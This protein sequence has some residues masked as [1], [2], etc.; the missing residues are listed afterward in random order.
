MSGPR[1]G[2]RETSA[3]VRATRA[4]R[5]RKQASKSPAAASDVLIA[6]STSFPTREPAA[7]CTRP[8]DPTMLRRAGRVHASSDDEGGESPGVGVDRVALG[9]A[10]EPGGR[11]RGP[12][13]AG[14]QQG[15][16]HRRARVGVPTERGDA[17]EPRLEPEALAHDLARDPGGQPREA[18]VRPVERA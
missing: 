3:A 16:R 10:I 5:S 8:R 11:D 12:A 2:S 15:A 14:P 1:S 7:A 4:K 18:A 6:S 9:D 13:V 17:T